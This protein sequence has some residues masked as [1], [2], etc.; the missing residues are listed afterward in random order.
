MYGCNSFE[1]ACLGVVCRTH[2]KCTGFSTQWR[3]EKPPIGIARPSPIEH[4]SR[5]PGPADPEM[6]NC[7]RRDVRQRV[8]YYGATSLEPVASA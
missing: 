4:E 2:G 8:P 7:C 6:E 3:D 1:T 5:N